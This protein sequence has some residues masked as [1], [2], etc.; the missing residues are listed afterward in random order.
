[1][2]LNDMQIEQMI[3]RGHLVRPM[4]AV[5]FEDGFVDYATD[6]SERGQIQP[7]SLDIRLGNSFK[8]PIT[9]DIGFNTFG[10]DIK[11][12]SLDVDSVILRPHSFILA[13]SQEYVSLP[14]DLT[15]F[16]EGR[17]SIGRMG[18]FIQNAGWIDPG[19]EGQ[20]TF[21]LFNASDVPIQLTSDIRIAQ[22][23]FVKMSNPCRRPYKGKY[24]YQTGATGSRINLDAE[25]VERSNK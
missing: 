22:L 15:A 3:Q 24:Q 5:P 20:I 8:R 12:E 6:L 10:S 1:M 7:A 14:D 11:Y 25:I 9:P 16:V 19:F 4:I 2:V 13:T 23:V 17:S 18:L 21:E